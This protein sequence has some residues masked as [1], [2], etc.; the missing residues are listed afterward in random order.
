SLAS[1]ESETI[2]YSY[3]VVEYDD[4]GQELS[5]TETAAT[6]TIIGTN[7]GPI[8]RNDSNAIGEN[9]TLNVTELNGLLKNDSDIDGDKL[10]VIGIRTGAESATNSESGIVGSELAGSFGTLTVN[11]DGSYKYVADNAESLKVGETVSE[12]FTYTISDGQ[13]GT[14]T[15]TLTITVTGTNDG[16]KANDD[17]YGVETTTLLFSESFEHMA[18]TGKW[19]VVSGDQLD[20]WNGTN[21][22]EIQR[23]GLIAKATDGDYIAEL[24]AHQNTA[25]TTSI[26][27]AGQDSVRVEFD[28]NPRRDGDSSSDMKFTFGAETITVH[29]DGTVSGSDISNV[30]IVGPDSDGWYKVTAEFDVQGDSTDLTFAGAGKSDSYGA[31]LDNITV[32]GVNKPNLTTP[33]DTTIEITF[34]ELLANDTDVDGD[35]LSIVEGSIASPTHGQLEVDYENGV[36]KFKPD[37]NY[38]GEAT[39]KYTVTDGNGGYDD[40]TVT[41]NVTPV[42]D[43]PVATDDVHTLG[44]NLILNGSFESFTSSSSPS[45]G[46]RASSLDNWEFTAN[47]GKLDLVEDGYKNVSTDGDRFIDMEGEGGRG[48]NVTLSQTVNGVEE[49]KP[50]QISLDVAA[51]GENHTAKIQVVWNGVVIATITPDSNTMETHTFEVIGAAGDNTISFVEVGG[52][53]DNSGTYLDNIKLQE[54]LVD[55]T[56]DEDTTLEIPHSQLLANDFDVDGD[57]LT[58]TSVSMTDPSHGEVKLVGGNVVFEPAD[59]FNGVTTFKYTISD[60]NGGTDTATVTV[61]V[62]PVNDAPEFISGNDQPGDAPNVDV[63]DFKSVPEQ[64]KAGTLIGVVKAE[65]VD[66]DELTYSFSNGELTNGVFNIDPNSGEITLNKEIDDADLGSFE[67]VVEVKDGNGSKDTATVNVDLTNVEEDSEIIIDKDEGDSDQGS[68]TEDLDTDPDTT[69]VQLEVSGT[70]TVIDEDGDGAFSTDV[71]FKSSTGKDENDQLLGQLGTL[72]IDKDGNWSYEVNNDSKYVQSLTKGETIVETYEVTT[73]DGKDTQ[74]VVITINGA[75]DA[76]P[77]IEVENTDGDVTAADN[78]VVEA[79]G[80]AVTGTITVGAQA[81]ID[82]VTINNVDITG[83]TAQTPVTV[84]GG[85]VVT[86]YDAQTGEVSY[87]Y[88]EDGQADSHASGAVVDSFTVV[89]TDLAGQSH[90]DTLDIEIIDTESTAMADADEVTEDGKQV[91]TGNVLTN[92]DEGAD[93]PTTVMDVSGGTKAANGDIT[94]QGTYGTL[95]M[96][97]DGSYTYTLNN[98]SKAVQSLTGNDKPTETFEYTLTDADGD[99]SKANL[100][101]TVNGADD[102]KPTIEVENTDGDVTAADNSV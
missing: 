85:L 89:V 15:A 45:W 69:G 42:N 87:T 53:G 18:N 31:L 14:D 49:G 88:T 83:A 35:V 8:A 75:D 90:S 66:G 7:D 23:D 68:V 51:R 3:D 9:T 77:T 13:G 52:A 97:A 78:S 36:I 21:G 46:D 1:G 74:T 30:Q 54:V 41:L 102:A 2:T 17:K 37:A 81:G 96:K 79:T 65:D 12:T 4:E 26:N 22:L 44:N 16:P 28:Y 24:D 62:K 94:V 61:N 98:E 59:N 32:T 57:T 70:L 63:Y 20:D 33:E 29:A 55:L 84:G 60:G 50:Y 48:D 5:R 67:L 27:T 92:D 71:T 72:T 43:P 34:A 101:I 99:Q 76:K 19:T 25:I 10:E 47:S 82:G 6:I 95:V 91:A 56:T 38:N 93:E 73:V 100:V 86:G 39:F 64:S 58:I 11:A 40:A 80:E